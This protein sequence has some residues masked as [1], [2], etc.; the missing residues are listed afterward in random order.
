MMEPGVDWVAGPSERV[1]WLAER[2]RAKG[3]RPGAPMGHRT[4]SLG[5]SVLYMP[6]SP[7]STTSA[8]SGTTMSTGSF[9]PVT[10][11]SML[12][13]SPSTS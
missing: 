13:D 8:G 9:T 4:R 5:L 3:T 2:L 7:R 6:K 10:V 12:I 11:R 1:D